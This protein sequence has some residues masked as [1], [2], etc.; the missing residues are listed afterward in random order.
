M[1]MLFGVVSRWILTC[2]TRNQDWIS[3]AQRSLISTSMNAFGGFQR[4]CVE[5]Q[6]ET[7]S[8]SISSH[9]SSNS[10]SKQFLF[11]LARFNEQCNANEL[12]KQGISSTE[13][14]VKYK[15]LIVF[16][17]YI[18]FV[19][20]WR[21]SIR[22]MSMGFQTFHDL[23]K[24]KRGMHF[25]KRSFGQDSLLTPKSCFVSIRQPKQLRKFEQSSR[26]TGQ[27]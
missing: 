16:F 26:T 25:R 18:L 4:L 15:H 27:K 3:E 1:Q 20:R 11:L 8:S 6:V 19:F 12:E 14:I 13:V 24:N 23:M 21:M 7:D 2:S 9:H 17:G 5:R 10:I 22:G